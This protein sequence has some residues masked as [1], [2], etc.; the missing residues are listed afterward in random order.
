MAVTAD[1]APA[2]SWYEVAWWCLVSVAIAAFV[3]VVLRL[4]GEARGI[5]GI[6]LVDVLIIRRRPR[7]WQDRLSIMLGMAAAVLALQWLAWKAGLIRK[8]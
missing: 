4:P 3:W 6:L 5:L 8:M 2:M 7:P 1:V